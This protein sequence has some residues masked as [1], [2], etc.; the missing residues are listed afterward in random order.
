MSSLSKP[1][2]VWTNRVRNLA[3]YAGLKGRDMER[4]LDWYL[5][6]GRRFFNQ[7]SH[8]IIKAYKWCFIVGCN[9]SGTS[10]LQSALEKSGQVTTLPHEGQL[11]TTAL[12]RAIRRGY[13]RV[14]SEYL[15]N[16]KLTDGDRLECL[17]RLLHDWLR[18]FSLPICE[19]ILEKTPAHTARMTWLQKAFPHSYFIGLVRNG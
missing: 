10:L 15:E 16:L 12:P 14:W 19:I 5:G 7:H 2:A 18:E 6:G 13:E 9:N 1:V 8:E 3:F 11:Y 17:P 4:A